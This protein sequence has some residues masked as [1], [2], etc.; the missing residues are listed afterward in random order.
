MRLKIVSDGTGRGTQLF[1]ADT[2][3]TVDLQKM[4]IKSI[5]WKLDASERFATVSLELLKVPV[6]LTGR[7]HD[8]DPRILQTTLPRTS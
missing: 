1:D 4:Q 5:T 2:G 8:L 7:S 3:E 6:E